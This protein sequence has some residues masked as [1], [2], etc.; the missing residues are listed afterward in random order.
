M[1]KAKAEA[2]QQASVLA[3]GEK[4]FIRTVTHY[5]TGEIEALSAETIT[6]KDAAWIAD[7]ARFGVALTTGALNEV[8]PYP[9][10]VEVFRGACVDI[11]KWPHPLPREA[12]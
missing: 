3:V 7:T 8:E 1:A 4:V 11:C 12:K 2:K 9:G 6:L 5:Y 10:G